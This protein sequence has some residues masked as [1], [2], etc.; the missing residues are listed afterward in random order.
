MHEEREPSP[1]KASPSLT[2]L[3]G[4]IHSFI[5]S[6]ICQQTCLES[7]CASSKPG[8]ADAEMNTELTGR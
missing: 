1:R 3:P 6:F 7:L 2:L 8:A 4:Q 5:H